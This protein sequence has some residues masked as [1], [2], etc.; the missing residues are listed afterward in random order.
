[1]IVYAY[2]STT[3]LNLKY[4]I[5]KITVNKLKIYH[6]KKSNVYTDSGALAVLSIYK[7]FGMTVSPLVPPQISASLDVL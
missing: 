3:G 7:T 4:G 5:L 2:I 1:M 6:R